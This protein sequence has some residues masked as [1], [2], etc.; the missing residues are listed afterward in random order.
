MDNVKNILVHALVNLGDVVL[1]TSAIALLK[2]ICPEAKVTILVKA[3]SAELVYDNPVIDEVLVFQYKEKQKSWQ[4]M[5]NLTQELRRRSFDM[6]ISLDRKLRPALLTLLAG[7]PVRV[8]PDRIFDNKTSWMTKL[9]THTIHT[10]DDFMNTHQSQLFQSIIRGIFKKQ[11]TALPVIAKIMPNH[12]EQAQHLLAQLPQATLKIGLCVK[13]T[14]FLKNWPQAKFVELVKKLAQTY[15]ASFFIVGAPDDHEYAE[16]V[17]AQSDTSIV[18]FCGQTNLLDFAALIEMSDL[19][20]TIDT[21]GMHIAATTQTP[22]IG[23][24][25]CVSTIRWYPLSDKGYAVSGKRR[26]CLPVASPENCPM[27]YCVQDIE[28]EDV[29]TVAKQ[30]IDNQEMK[31]ANKQGD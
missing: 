14:Y 10:P 23:L 4:A 3:S 7:I 5:W 27:Y 8:G 30:I 2:Q 24:F 19:F 28:V 22:V 25:R 18:N 6:S 15:D 29:F 16:Q 26:D 13:G 17:I 12:R 31:G 20:I 9:F 11:G 21:G 1:A